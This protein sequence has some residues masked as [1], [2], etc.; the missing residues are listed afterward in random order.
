MYLC[1][2]TTTIPRLLLLFSPPLT[3]CLSPACPGIAEVCGPALS[4][5]VHLAQI[6]FVVLAGVTAYVGRTYLYNKDLSVAF[7]PHL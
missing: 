6:Y 3:Y 5:L 2:M 7:L 1:T 4:F